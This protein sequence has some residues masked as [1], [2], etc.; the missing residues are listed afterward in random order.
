[1]YSASYAMTVPY[2]TR[3]REVGSARDPISCPARLEK[4]SRRTWHRQVLFGLK[5]ILGSLPPVSHHS[6]TRFETPL[7]RWIRLFPGRHTICGHTG[8]LR[9]RRTRQSHIRERDGGGF[10]HWLSLSGDPGYLSIWCEAIPERVRLHR[11]SA[12]VM[13]IRLPWRLGGKNEA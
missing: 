10:P 1:M 11:F 5:L 9:S 6:S 2:L 8:L 3:R 7:V 12:T 13:L 4:R